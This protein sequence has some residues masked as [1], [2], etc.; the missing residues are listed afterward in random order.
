MQQ[1]SLKKKPQDYKN[2]HETILKTLIRDRSIVE[3]ELTDGSDVRGRITQFDNYTIT[4]MVLCI[5][6][7]SMR[8]RMNEHPIKPSDS[9]PL[10]TEKGLRTYFKSQIKCFGVANV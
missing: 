5:Q 10:I 2:G 1:A 7:K 6:Y 3:V 4:I 8:D 9:E